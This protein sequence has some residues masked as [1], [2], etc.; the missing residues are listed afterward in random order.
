MH[1]YIRALPSYSFSSSSTSSQSRS[2][3]ALPDFICQL[4]IAVGT[5]GPHLPALDRS[6]SPDFICQLHIAEG[7]AGPEPGAPDPSGHCQTPTASPRSHSA[8]RR[9]PTSDSMPDR[10]LERMPDRMPEYMSDEMPD[11]NVR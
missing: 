5:A 1:R 6:G 3:W 9:A 4:P 8:H 7:T 10:M 11:M 2:R